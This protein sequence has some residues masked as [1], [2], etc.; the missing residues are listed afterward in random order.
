MKHAFAYKKIQQKWTP[1]HA[2]RP[3]L[4]NLLLKISKILSIEEFYQR[5]LQPIIETRSSEVIEKWQAFFGETRY[6]C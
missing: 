6:F 5:N 2:A 4:A 3:F 1:A